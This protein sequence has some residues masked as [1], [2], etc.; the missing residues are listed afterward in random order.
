M[1]VLGVVSANYDLSSK[2]F[3]SSQALKNAADSWGGPKRRRAFLT[4]LSLLAALLAKLIFVFSVFCVFYIF[5]FKPRLTFFSCYHFLLSFFFCFFVTF[6]DLFV[7]K[8]FFC[9]FLLHFTN[10]FHFF[11]SFFSPFFCLH[12]VFISFS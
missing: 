7:L 12:F 3:T 11:V 9:S 5:F 8:S 4:F 1:C 6:L 10:V 2:R